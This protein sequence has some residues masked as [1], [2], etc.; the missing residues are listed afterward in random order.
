VDNDSGYGD[1]G[2]DVTLDDQAPNGD[3]HSYRAT[4]FGNHNIPL[5]GPLTDALYGPW[6]PDAR[7]DDPSV[8][9]LEN[10][11]HRDATLSG[12]NGS[13]VGG[14]WTLFL[15]DTSVG[16]QVMLDKWSLEITAIAVPEP[17]GW[18]PAA[19]IAL[20]ALWAKAAINRTR[21]KRVQTESP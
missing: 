19:F 10:T 3:I 17:A 1:P 20:A 11:A 13:P 16:G 12:F 7:R 14:D 8:V 18:L 4:I 9:T 5:G 2:F 21:A 6:S 15:A